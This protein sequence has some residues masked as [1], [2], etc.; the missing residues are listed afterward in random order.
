MRFTRAVFAIALALQGLVIQGT[1]D[2]QSPLPGRT[3]T[4]SGVVTSA[5]GQNLGAADVS[6]SGPSTAKAQTSNDGKFSIPGLTPGIYTL[7][8]SKASFQTANTTDIAL[9]EGQTVTLTVT[10]QPATFSQLQTIATVSSSGAR[11]INTSTASVA[12]VSGQVFVDQG[13]QQ[14]TAVLNEIP[15]VITTIPASGTNISGAAANT[16]QIPQI[17]GALPYET[18]SLIDGHPVSVGINGYFTPLFLNP[19]QVQ[20]VEVSKGPGSMPTDISYAVGG[21]V[22]YITLAPTLKPKSSIS[23][24]YDSYGG[25]ST[26]A[27]ATGTI[28][29]KLGY[30][31]AFG[32]DGT[33][34]PFH[35]FPAV[36]GFPISAIT[37]T[38]T[39]NGVP[40]CGAFSNFSSCIEG[41]NPTLPGYYS[42]FSPTYAITTCCYQIQSQYLTRSELAKLRFD[43]STQSS[44]TVAFLGAQSSSANPQNYW[45]PQQTFV[46]PAGYSG[47]IPSGTSVPF[48]TDVGSAWQDIVN[49]GILESEFR[50]SVGPASILFRYY[51]GANDNNLSLSGGTSTAPNNF[52]IDT[53]GGLP[54]G[55][56]GSEV[57]FN[58]TPVNYSAVD[59]GLV[60]ANEDHFSGMS[61]EID[62]PVGSSTFTFSADR[63]SHNSSSGYIFPVASNSFFEIPD[64]ASQAL[65][66]YLAKGQFQITPQ[67]SAIWGNYFVNYSTHFTPDGGMTW[68]DASHSLYLPRFAFAFRPGV[69]TSIRFSAGSSF[70]PP[71][72][73]LVNAAGGPPEP[74]I[75]GAPTSYTEIQNTGNISPE[76]AFGYDLGADRRITPDTIV[77]SDVYYT[78][79]HGQFLTSTTADGTYTP[80]SGQDL[81][82]TAPLYIQAT[83]NLGTSTMFGW[84][85][86]IH[87]SPS[88]GF[89][90]TASLSLTR[91]YV[92]DLPPGFYNTAQG[93]NTTNLGV[94]PYVNFMPGGEAFNGSSIGGRV[95]YATG[96]GELNYRTRSGDLFL[97]GTQYNGNNNS[98]NVPAFF[99]VNASARFKLGSSTSIQGSVANLTSV[100]SEPYF[101][102]QNGIP[103]PLVNGLLG[104]LPQINVGPTTYHIILTQSLGGH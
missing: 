23:F 63:T 90:Y 76:T 44:L 28:S 70:A 8:V 62:V 101:G 36:Q 87:K 71:Y 100:H 89:G 65:T 64:G 46:P 11:S 81:G 9:I 72:L 94:I 6:V 55:P 30:A 58:G 34:G 88:V 7:S 49:Q 57:F 10:L 85:L 82:L 83:T 74:N 75:F 68:S 24:D 77:S 21:S 99:T 95:P 102:L 25:L 67:L 54:I 41:S 40:L 91:A 5:S 96:Y 50:S 66:T 98:Y 33:P 19:N 29:N 86:E 47:S 80:T 69:D 60:I 39:A 35:N 4:I 45:D 26:N 56:G 42:T 92:E 3:G 104:A 79:L 53:W 43:F 97:I 93:P 27:R 37:G 31:F 14:V 103:V 13:L 59:S 52:T 48:G 18:E 20:E 16:P 22:N 32:I 1:A 73:A 78:G 17:R 38:T 15:G 12:N 2:A 51:T 61:G 84:E